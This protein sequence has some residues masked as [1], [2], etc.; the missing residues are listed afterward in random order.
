[1]AAKLPKPRADALAARLEL[2]LDG[3]CL[4]CLSFVSSAVDRG[5]EREIR[6]QLYAMTP[7]LWADG[8]DVTAV[9]AVRE[10]C[11]RGV[12]DAPEALAELG[13]AGS[14]SAV[15]RAIVRR[16]AEDLVRRTSLELRLE[17]RSRPR[18]PLAPPELN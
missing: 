13:S 1:M 9:A 14:R 12:P 18:L 15:A 6:R 10:A 4:A 3:V 16:L 5:G 8:L 7:D 17:E 2:S 11:A